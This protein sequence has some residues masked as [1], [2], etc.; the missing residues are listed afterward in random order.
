MYSHFTFL[1]VCHFMTCYDDRFGSSHKRSDCRHLLLFHGIQLLT[2]VSILIVMVNV[3]KYTIH[4]CYALG[5]PNTHQPA[6]LT[7]QE[8]AWL[9]RVRELREQV[10]EPETL[11]VS[12]VGFEDRIPP[13]EL[14]YP[15]KLEK[16]H[17][18]PIIFGW[19]ILVPRRV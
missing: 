8:I 1:S 12:C 11:P 19:D 4:G 9:T 17:H 10:G 2:A 6:P 15:T 16:E 5:V 3:C 14:T 7:F 13:G 18:F